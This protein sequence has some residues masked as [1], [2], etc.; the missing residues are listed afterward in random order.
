[1]EAGGATLSKLHTVISRAFAQAV[2]D[3]VISSNPA[4]RPGLPK[5]SKRKVRVLR[6][7]EV[8]SVAEA[9]D[10]RYRAMVADALG[11]VAPYAWR[12]GVPLFLVV[13]LSLGAA[14]LIDLIGAAAEEAISALIQQAAGA[15]CDFWADHQIETRLEGD[16]FVVYLSVPLIAQLQR[17]CFVVA[18]E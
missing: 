16:Q 6:P 14:W 10:P 2:R 8:E 18:R 3:G 9:I 17:V 7:E 1:M 13:L 12:K 11:E 5:A 15:D 4:S